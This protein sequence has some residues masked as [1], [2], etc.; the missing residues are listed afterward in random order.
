MHRRILGS[1]FDIEAFNVWQMLMYQ[2]VSLFRSCPLLPMANL[3][4]IKR[5]Y[6]HQS[7][8]LLGQMECKIRTTS[9]WRIKAWPT[10]VLNH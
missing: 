7:G 5:I 10:I 3:K 4:T 6:L 2:C 1:V 9:T 8:V